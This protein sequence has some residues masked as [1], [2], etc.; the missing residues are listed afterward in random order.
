MRSTPAPSTRRP[1]PIVTVAAPYS[2]PPGVR[3]HRSPSAN[4]TITVPYSSGPAGCSRSTITAAGSLANKPPPVRSTSPPADR[5][6]SPPGGIRYT[7]AS[8]AP[9]APPPTP[10]RPLSARRPKR[11]GKTDSER[12]EALALRQGDATAVGDDQRHAFRHRGARGIRRR[13]RRGSDRRN[14]QRRRRHHRPGQGHRTRLSIPTGKLVPVE[15]DS[16]DPCQPRSPAT[17]RTSR[18]RGRPDPP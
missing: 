6:G 3:P 13:H 4:S 10:C 17:I 8:S 11:P 5:A 14:R 2:G 9:A 1:A 15:M 12:F 16:Y 7:S 18:R